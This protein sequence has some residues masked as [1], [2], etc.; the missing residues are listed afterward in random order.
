KAVVETCEQRDP[1]GLYKKARA[2]EIPQ[3]T[4]VPAPYEAPEA[5]DLE[6]DT[7]TETVPES[8]ERIVRYVEKV[9]T[10]KGD[11]RSKV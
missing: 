2:G 7:S 1:R 11:D 3:S 4:G 6:V 9:F 8:V 5:A 10:L